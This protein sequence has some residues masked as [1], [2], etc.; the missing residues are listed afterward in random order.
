MYYVTF[1]QFNGSLLN[2]SIIFFSIILLQISLS[3]CIYN[4]L[5]TVVWPKYY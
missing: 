4:I 1:D 3:L 5:L 2:K